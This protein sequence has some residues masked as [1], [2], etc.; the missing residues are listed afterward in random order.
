MFR[1]SDRKDNLAPQ[2]CRLRRARQDLADPAS[3]P[4]E[5][6]MSIRSADDTHRDLVSADAGHAR[7]RRALGAF[8]TPRR[9][10]Q[11]K[12]SR[13]SKARG[14]ALR[15]CNSER[16]S[17]APTGNACD[18]SASSDDGAPSQRAK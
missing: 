2:G 11:K 9:S 1:A 6:S 12:A 3:R 7:R 18:A 10:L 5:E 17:R 15:V 8:A 4:T 16:L 13:T 14:T